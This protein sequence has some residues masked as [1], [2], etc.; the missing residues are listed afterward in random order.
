M[1]PDTSA[2]GRQYGM[3]FSMN[4]LCRSA[5]HIVIAALCEGEMS[6]HSRRVK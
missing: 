4:P 1:I 3:I 5:G 2:D 6:E